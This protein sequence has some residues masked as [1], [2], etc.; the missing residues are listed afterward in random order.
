MYSNPSNS[1]WSILLMTSLRRRR[2]KKN[3]KEN[4]V[5]VVPVK[6][7][8]LAL[9]GFYSANLNINTWWPAI[10]NMSRLTEK[11]QTCFYAVI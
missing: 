10:G 2:R 1:D 8:H 3:K 9:F 7:N 4:P 11:K 5:R 6:T